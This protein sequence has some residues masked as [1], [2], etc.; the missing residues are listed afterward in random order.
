MPNSDPKSSDHAHFFESGEREWQAARFDLARG[1][2]L[3]ALPHKLSP[4]QARTLQNRIK[5]LN[6][7]RFVNPYFIGA[8]LPLSGKRRALGQKVL[9]GLSLGLGLAEGGSPYKLIVK[10]SQSRASVV[11]HALSSLLQK[12]YIIG[13]AGGLSA[14]TAQ[15]MARTGES[16]AIPSLLFSQKQGLSQ[17]R[18]FIFQTAV[19]AKALM[20]RLSQRLL[21]DSIQKAALLFPEDNYGTA[22]SALFKE[23][24]Q[25]AGGQITDEESYSPG[26]TDFKRALRSLTHIDPLKERKKE[27]EDLKK[28]FLQ[29]NPRLSPRDKALSPD[30]LLE[31]Q[32]D[33]Q[34]LFVPD[35]SQ[36]LR[37]IASYLKYFHIK[38]IVIAGAHL[39]RPDRVRDVAKDFS[40]VFPAPLRPSP[41]DRG[42]S[43]FYREYQKA[44][45]KEPGFFE[46]EAYNAGAALRAALASRPKDR[47]ELQQALSQLKNFKGAGSD[48]K[49]EDRT[50][51]RPIQIHALSPPRDGRRR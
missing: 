19:S 20:R 30:R 5:A 36:S 13:A 38:G 25:K 22:L 18:I 17:N 44:F 8:V 39:W 1:F 3:R 41:R 43:S 6:Y 2:F 12:R 50:F 29:Q 16:L 37:R 51:V 28:E 27:Y 4:G 14:E 33:F 40:L 47:F 11:S 48:I 24:F 34:A 9:N 49:I 10:D 23:E 21:Q 31:P 42:R 35:S 7:R 26:E 45:L 15:A 32:V 46:E